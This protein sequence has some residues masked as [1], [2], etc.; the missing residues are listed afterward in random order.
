[1]DELLRL[2]EEE[3]KLSEQIKNNI[4][5]KVQEKDSEKINEYD[6]KIKD[7]KQKILECRVNIELAKTANLERGKTR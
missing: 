5:L 4:V 3:E 1:M 6:Q 7:L 2:K